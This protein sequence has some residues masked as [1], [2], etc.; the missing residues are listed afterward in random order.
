MRSGV[1]GNSVTVTPNGR[2][3]SSMALATA[4]GTMPGVPSPLPLEP[5]GVWGE[6]TL[7]SMVSMCGRSS[8]DGMW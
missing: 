1:S 2:S 6:G 5:S 8:D 4:A 3:A 7:C